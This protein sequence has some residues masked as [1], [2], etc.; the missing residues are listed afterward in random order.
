MFLLVRTAEKV[1]GNLAE[2]TGRVAPCDVSTVYGIRKAMGVAV[3]PGPPEPLIGLSTGK[4]GLTSA[5]VLSEE[6]SAY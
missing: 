1:T 4:T 5:R 2:L 3:P 6:H